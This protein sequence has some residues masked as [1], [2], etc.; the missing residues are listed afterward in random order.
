MRFSC[1]YRADLL[2]DLLTHRHQFLGA[3]KQR[4]P[5]AVSVSNSIQC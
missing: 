1:E 5:S 2:T 4:D 3:E